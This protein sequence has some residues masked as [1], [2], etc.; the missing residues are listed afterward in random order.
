M[1]ER[2]ESSVITQADKEGVVGIKRAGGLGGGG[3]EGRSI[4]FMAK[5]SICMSGRKFFKVS[6]IRKLETGHISSTIERKP[7]RPVKG[8]LIA[9]GIR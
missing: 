1:K 2:R 4:N 6:L 8:V 5:A 7:G 3:K 9:P